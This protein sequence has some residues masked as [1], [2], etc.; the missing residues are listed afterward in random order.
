[1]TKLN[2]SELVGAKNIDALIAEITE[3]G[4]K[5]DH[6][7]W[8]AAVSAML[9]HSG[10]GQTGKIN[11]VLRAM[12]NGSRTNAMKDFILAHGAVNWNEEKE[13]FTHD[14]KGT[15]DLDG[16]LAK[17]WTEYKPEQPYRPVDALKLIQAVVTKITKEREE[18]DK[19][20]D[21]QAQHILECAAKMGIEV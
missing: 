6:K 5:L 14:K 17:S 13:V 11:D 10:C 8:I 19:V 21:T 2:K 20:T 9:L 7:L 1:M 12:P 15:F 4:A 18:G 3:I 16:A